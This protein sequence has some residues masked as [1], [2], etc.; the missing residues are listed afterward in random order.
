M[1]VRGLRRRELNKKKAIIRKL[2][3]KIGSKL[4]N[5]K[6]HKSQVTNSTQLTKVKM[7]KSRK[8]SKSHHIT[9]KHPKY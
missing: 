1:E 6:S 8:E 5:W 2:V 7:N 9:V 3:I 4:N